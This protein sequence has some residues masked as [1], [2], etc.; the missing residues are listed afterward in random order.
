[1]S[2]SSQFGENATTIKSDI[3]AAYEPASDDLSETKTAALPTS[4]LC[5]K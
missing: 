2:V 1:M 5:I 4:P 3:E